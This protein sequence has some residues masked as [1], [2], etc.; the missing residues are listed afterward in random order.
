MTGRA[1]TQAISATE[2]TEGDSDT[3]AHQASL[4]EALADVPQ[5]PPRLVTPTAE[6]IS[7]EPSG[8]ATGNETQPSLFGGRS[9]RATGP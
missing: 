1:T 2:L 9:Q 3:P 8:K 5:S 6:D 7:V 4:G